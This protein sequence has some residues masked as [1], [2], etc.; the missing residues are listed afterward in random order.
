[1]PQGNEYSYQET[2]RRNAGFFE[3]IEEG[4]QPD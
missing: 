3:L 4:T 1:M 2:L